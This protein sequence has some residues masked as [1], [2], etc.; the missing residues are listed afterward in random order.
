MNLSAIIVVVAVGD[1]C[2]TC[3]S[4]PLWPVDAFVRCLNFLNLEK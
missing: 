3:T 2:D 1:G 4:Q